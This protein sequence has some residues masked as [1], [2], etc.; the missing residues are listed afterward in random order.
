MTDESSVTIMA[1]SS[2]RL[3]PSPTSLPTVSS[4]SSALCFSSVSP[5]SPD[6]Q[7]SRLVSSGIS[8]LSQTEDDG[9]SG[10]AR[11]FD[12]SRSSTVNAVDVSGAQAACQDDE[13]EDPTV[14]RA[15]AWLRSRGILPPEPSPEPLVAATLG[16]PPRS[17]EEQSASSSSSR[18]PSR[19]RPPKSWSSNPAPVL[20]EEPP[21]TKHTNANSV[22]HGFLEAAES[23]GS[24][25]TLNPRSPDFASA[26]VQPE[27][28]YSTRGF[29]PTSRPRSADATSG[30]HPGSL[31]GTSDPCST[32]RRSIET[33]RLEAYNDR[34]RA[35]AQSATQPQ[36]YGGAE[37]AV[38][39]AQRRSAS[40]LR[41]KAEEERAARVQ[42]LGPNG[43][44]VALTTRELFRRRDERL[45]RFLEKGL[46]G[47]AGFSPSAE[48]AGDR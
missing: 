2:T 17:P 29:K 7:S 31:Q 43:E 27:R 1:R 38:R 10:Q 33:R 15:R 24:S 23:L 36:S 26:N 20:L 21:P 34:V 45:R 48:D 46:A 32:A 22:T 25:T 39:R 9:R 5:V 16:V 44:L 30:Y 42:N 18:C 47:A 11:G 41:R 4:G 3:Q 37:E 19:L 14:R 8:W 12:S 35:R 6:P 28:S 13:D 40:A